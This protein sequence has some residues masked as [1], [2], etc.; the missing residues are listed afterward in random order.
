MKVEHLAV[1]GA[2]FLA[3]KS[4]R[5]SALQLKQQEQMMNG[6]IE[7]FDEPDLAYAKL[8]YMKLSKTYSPEQAMDMVIAKGIGL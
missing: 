3:F 8:D 5:R 4:S 1:A 7:F 6:L 2:L